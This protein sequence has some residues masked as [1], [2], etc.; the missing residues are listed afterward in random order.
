MKC[1][2]VCPS[3]AISVFGLEITAGELFE[4]LLRDRPFYSKS[5]GGVTFSG[6]EPLRQVDFLVE[7]L[8]ICREYSLHTAVDTAGS[9][10]FETFLSVLPYTDL[11]L[12]DIKAMDP[13]L[14]RRFT[15]ADNAR[16]LENLQ[17]LADHHA[18]VWVRV[19][20]IPGFNDGEEE[21]AAIAA[22]LRNIPV[23][24][25]IE[26]LPYHTFGEAKYDHLGIIHN[27]EERRVPDRA[28]LLRVLKT[29][30]AGGLR[31]ECPAV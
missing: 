27:M 6:G 23:V 16:I 1:A 25:K 24:E 10:P 11:F 14:H 19:P 28:E 22:F 20:Y 2:A 18:R 21:I 9:V 4:I 12:Y 5:G 30:H 15:G 26:L 13:G 31:V 7:I 3:G 8:K 29:Y 17:R